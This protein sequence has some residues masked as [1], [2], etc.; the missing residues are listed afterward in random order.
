MARHFIH[1]SDTDAVS[2]FASLLDRVRAGA[3]IVIEHSARP[4]VVV[5]PAELLAGRLLSES[6]ALAEA[7]AKNLGCEPTIDPGFAAD[8]REIINSRKRVTSRH[9]TNSRFQR[10]HRR[11]TRGRTLRE[12]LMGIEAIHGEMPTTDRSGIRRSIV[13]GGR[14]YGTD[15]SPTARQRSS[16]V[17]R[18]PRTLRAKALRRSRST[19]CV[20]CRRIG[21]NG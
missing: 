13:L 16:R 4:V 14:Y 7:H 17:S 9:G 21:E 15:R 1:V 12:I 8:L 2:D 18:R 19:V 3:E 20:R 6:I 5:Q 11:R 10:P